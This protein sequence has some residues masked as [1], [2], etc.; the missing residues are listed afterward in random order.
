MISNPSPKIAAVAI[1]ALACLIASPHE[2]PPRVTVEPERLTFPKRVV[3]T[4]SQPQFVILHNL[5]EEI[6]TI[7]SVVATGDFAVATNTCGASAAPEAQCKI[8]VTFT[9]T[10]E[11]DRTGTLRVTDDAD[12]SPQTVAL[13]GE[14]IPITLER[15]TVSPSTASVGTFLTQ[16]FTATGTFNNGTTRDLTSSVAWS[17]EQGA[18]GGT[19]TSTGLYTAPATAGVFEVVATN[20]KPRRTAEA[21]VTVVANQPPVANAGGPYTGVVGQQIAFN[22]SASSDPDGDTLAF[23]WNF[24]D[25]S[26]GTGAM[27]TH[28]YAAAGTFTVSLTVNDGRGA[29]STA[30]TTA[31]ITSTT[32]VITDFNPKSGPIGTLVTITGSNFV[33]PTGNSP[34]VTLNKQGGGT[35]GATLASFT[36]TSIAFAVPDGAASGPLTVAQNGQSTTSAASLTI[37]AP[38]GFSLNASPATASVIQGQSVSYA[39]ALSSTSGFA[40]L[41]TLSVSGL[42]SGVTASFS[43]QQITANQTALLAVTAPASQAT[44]TSSLTVTAS[45]TVAGI[46]ESQ[47]ASVTLNVQPVSTT[48]LGRTVV[49]DSL[50]TPL[51]GVTVTMLGVDGNGGPTGCSGQTQSDAAG[52]FALTNLPSPCLGSQLVRFDG[53]TATSPPGKYAGVDLVF[54]MM[55]G[56]VTV[57]P[58]LVH[59]PRIDDKETVMVQQNAAMNQTFTFSSI[60]GLSVTVY[61]GTTFTLVDGTQPNPFP[62]TGIQV[63]VDRLP[64]VKTPNPMILMVFIVA[65]QPA[66]ATASQPV[67]VT[68]PNPI[69]TPPGVDMVLMT[70]DPTR[71]MMVPYGFGTVSSDATQIVPDPDP[72]HPGHRF[73]LVHFDWHGPMPPLPPQ[74]NPQPPCKQCPCPPPPPPMAGKPIDLSSGLEVITATDI[75][76]SGPRGS[77]S[78]ARTYRTLSGNPGPFGIGTN[79][80]YGYQ[81]GT[82]G[83]NRGQGVIQLVMPDGNQFPFNLQSNGILVNTTIPSLR[84]AV[85]TNPSSGVYNLRWKDGTTFQFHSGGIQVAFLAL[86]TDANGNVTTITLNPS[87]PGQVTQ[88]TDPVGRSL[89]LNYDS[90][91]RVTSITDPIGRAVQYTYNSQ[92]TLATVTDPAGGVTSY[93]YDPQNNQHLISV[94]DPRGVVIAQNTYDSN[95]RVVQ[96]VEADGGVLSLAYTLLNPTARAV[97]PVLKTVVTDPLGNQ[98]TYRFEPQGLLTDATDATG[99]TKSF[100]RDPQSS[101][102]VMA[103]A[104]TA[105]C[106]ACGASS[107][108]D[109]HFTLDAN[110]NVLTQTDALGNTGTFAYEPS[111]NKVTSIKDPLGNSTTFTY[112]SAGNLLTRTDANGHMTSF[113]Y[114]SFGQV[115][116]ITDPLGQKTTFSYDGQGNLISTTDPLGDTT[117]TVYDA[118]SRPV[119]T[120]DALGRKSITTYDPLGRVMAQ[121]NAQGNSTQFTYDAVGNLLSVTDAKGHPTLFTYDGLNRLLTKTDPL[122]KTDTR[123][124]DFNGNLITFVDRRG[125]ASQFT[126]DALNRLTG[127]TYQDATVAR[128][129][130]ANGR[131]VHVN[132]S[133]GGV[134]DFAYDLAGHLLSSAGPFGTVQYTYDAAG[135][136]AS[137]QVVGQSAL[138]YSYDPAGN[139]LSASLPQAS[140]NFAYDARNLPS[141]ITRAN[142]VSSGYAYDAAGR[143]L[144]ITHSRGQGIQIPL[145]Y[146][147]D[148]DGNRA[149]FTTNVAQPLV[150]QPVT[151][152]FDAAN[153]L[154]QSG[155]TSYSYDANGNLTS[156]SSAS[157][158]TAYIWGSRNR[159]QSI[160]AP[161]GQTTKFV[162]DFVANL[163]SQADSGASLNLTQNFILDDLTDIAYLSRSNGDS[164]SILAGRA[165]DQHLAAIH[166][167]GQVEYSL[168]D[169]TNDTTETTDQNGRA[170]STFSYEPFGLTTS[171][172][173]YPFKFTGR[174]TATGNL[175]Y[176]RARYFDSSVGRFLS[177]DPKGLS[178]GDIDFYRYAANNPLSRVDPTGLGNDF[179]GCIA[180]CWAQYSLPPTTISGANFNLVIAI[181]SAKFPPASLYLQL[182]KQ[183]KDMWD[184]LK[185]ATDC[186]PPP[187]GS[188]NGLNPFCL[189][190]TVPVFPAP[191]LP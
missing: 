183:M 110:G 177:E 54:T 4:T 166:T 190:I 34:V 130:D 87:V 36:A 44:G 118:I 2:R 94:T 159:L 131:L 113:A 173:S 97:S 165:V 151:S 167:S 132:D 107:A 93:A 100:S 65:F 56:Q 149:A 139:L 27:P 23:A 28:A 41:A 91:N 53:R 85:L 171:T 76:I 117:S 64:D 121:T 109:Q 38:S 63:P 78:I 1:I 175:Y 29:T 10:E 128:S 82:F 120:T 6:L 42:P 160:S 19:I 188:G 12:D 46:A 163:I 83:F 95:G 119:Q 191:V 133:A 45:A 148:A 61:A 150:T 168:V 33:S 169:A 181:L 138:A 135:R 102:L 162:Y 17:V 98:T 21:T 114:N 129:Y 152:Q 179:F 84:G 43:P 126:Y 143:V 136:T 88:V 66:N 158:T 182:A 116:Q 11:E 70:L 140:V 172:D 123:G 105:D 124:Y 89:I 145:S 170:V 68:F 81:L 101:S 112:D 71:G 69:N 154:F 8:G 15:L 153:R 176:Y 146:S 16:Q 174:T 73:G 74:T 55:A 127:E 24:G 161:N 185:C 106:S 3:G 32:P 18:A 37:V 7:S 30:N 49:D 115:I 141:N 156:V 52:N 142:G 72:N 104:G 14:G 77:I 31:T 125:Q 9:P 155:S 25:G 58:I 90:S 137:R 22:G 50:Q 103:I 184:F 26:A 189:P 180:G 40:Q 186:L 79:H 164:L 48:F 86:I 20:A 144:S 157:G 57:S 62:L 13:S 5:Q 67:A 108:G 59:L 60:P 147:Y 187:P 134:F 178:S 80:N 39:L 35:I 111:F 96:Q 51:A 122:G 47:S 75:D 99:Q 92:G